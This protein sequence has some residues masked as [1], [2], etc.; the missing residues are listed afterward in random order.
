MMTRADR[1]PGIVQYGADIVRMNPVH[2]EADDS[3]AVFRPEEA[4]ARDGAERGARFGHQ[5]AF[6]RVKGVGADAIHPVDRRMESDRADNMRGA[7][8]EPRWRR[9][10]G[11]LLERHP[12]NHRA[13]ALPRRH[14]LQDLVASPERA[15]PGGPV[16]LMR[17]ES[18][19][20]RADGRDIDRKAWCGLT[21][22][23]QQLG[24]YL[25]R[26]VRRALRIE[27]RAEHVRHMGQ[28]DDRMFLAR[29]SLGGIEVD[30]AVL[31]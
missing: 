24:A 29:D 27:D 17:G 31:D 30:P 16:H 7:R 11:R 9:Q 13:A 2:R 14:R 3:G 25:V 6:M 1:H 28:R 5:R 15:D 23:E 12:V 18:V 19:K 4:H 8:L 21:A 10:I 26:D 20:V 22:V